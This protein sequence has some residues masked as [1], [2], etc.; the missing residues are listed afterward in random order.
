MNTTKN[1]LLPLLCLLLMGS[2][3]CSSATAGRQKEKLTPEPLFYKS[4]LAPAPTLPPNRGY[5]LKE[6]ES[7]LC[8]SIPG[9][10]MLHDLDSSIKETVVFQGSKYGERVWSSVHYQAVKEK[11]LDD[12]E[13]KELQ[14]SE[15]NKWFEDTVTIACKGNYTGD[16]IANVKAFIAEINGIIGREKFAFQPEVAPANIIAEFYKEE[17]ENPH[18][19]VGESVCLRDNLR[20]LYY[21]VRGKIRINT[22][23]ASA[24]I[25][26][27]MS[28]RI[29]FTS[30][31][32]KF[33]KKNRLI[34]MYITNVREPKIRKLVLFHEL[35]HAI[36]LT[37]H[38]PYVDSNLFPLPLP[39]VEGGKAE[40]SV[41][42]GVAKL[43]T[44]CKT[45]VQMLYRPEVLQGMTIREAG[46]VLAALTPLATTPVSKIEAFLLDRKKMLE[47]EKTFLLDTIQERMD[48]KEE[49][50]KTL[51]QSAI[52]LKKL[53]KEV[54]SENKLSP[55]KVEGKSILEILELNDRRVRL[56]LEALQKELTEL[57]AD[58]SQNTKRKLKGLLRTI[59]LRK[60]D[61]QVYGEILKEI[62]DNIIMSRQ[63]DEENIALGSDLRTSPTLLGEKQGTL[64][65][66]SLKLRRLVRQ[67]LSIQQ[68]I[69]LLK[70]PRGAVGS[71]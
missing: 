61:R 36:G 71:R 47:D 34:K 35:L 4:I 60:E 41:T 25:L 29:K 2:A 64:E 6:I 13:I 14:S 46:R 3:A 58:G 15:I 9:Y 22:Y 55:D 39:I 69:K 70:Q 56:R 1:T 16:D 32:L 62:A 42:V 31:E 68:E 7:F 49:I 19:L 40:S 18:Q 26:I 63:L 52:D 57:Q 28:R 48:R 53:E 30:E 51:L 67:L 5:A 23:T 66:V 11:V 21:R 44:L 37:G 20:V 24:G 8:A 65:E 27:N 38:S 17:A 12:T 45:M 50:K 54:R 43:S 10:I 33:R 59:K